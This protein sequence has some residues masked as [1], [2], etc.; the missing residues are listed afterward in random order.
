MQQPLIRE[1]ASRMTIRDTFPNGDGGTEDVTWDRNTNLL[2][3][4]DSPAYFEGTTGL[5]TGSS[6]TA[7]YCVVATASRNGRELIVVVLGLPAATKLAGRMLLWC[8]RRALPHEAG[9]KK[10]ENGIGNG[11]HKDSRGHFS[12]KR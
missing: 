9:G 10:R 12:N 8:W 5:K 1:T 4:P 3:D 11:G 2:L 7:G 6:D